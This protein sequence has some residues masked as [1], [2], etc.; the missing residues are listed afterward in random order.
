MAKNL[1]YFLF[2][3]LFFFYG[4][5]TTYW[6][7]Q[8]DYLLPESYK[9]EKIDSR[10]IGIT[11]YNLYDIKNTINIDSLEKYPKYSMEGRGWEMI[12]WHKPSNEELLNLEKLFE[13][14][15]INSEFLNEINLDKELIAYAKGAV[16]SGLDDKNYELTNWIELYFLNM[17]DRRILHVGYGKF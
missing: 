7:M 13:F 17:K 15:D 2:I 10:E 1:S 4:C 5:E 11:T 8:E 9:L 12:K 6:E 3:V 14:E 16:D